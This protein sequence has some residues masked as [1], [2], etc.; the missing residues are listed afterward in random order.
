MDPNSLVLLAVVAGML[1]PMGFYLWKGW[2]LRSKSETIDGFFLNSGKL[3]DSEIEQTLV[4]TWM[5]VG[6]AIAGLIVMAYYY[7]VASF[8]AIITWVLGFLILRRHVPAIKKYCQR[9]ATLHGFL[10]TQYGSVIIKR[11]A[12]AV[13]VL[14]CLGVLS[15]E[16]IV[17]VALVHA[18][19]GIPSPVV[20]TVAFTFLFA[21]VAILYTA[22]GGFNAVIQTDRSQGLFIKIAIVSLLLIALFWTYGPIEAPGVPENFY[23]PAQ[24]QS[25]WE[26]LLNSADWRFFL[27][28][29]VF[30]LFLLPGDMGTWQRVNGAQS[31]TKARRGIVIA[32]FWTLALWLVLVFVGYLVK[33]APP[34]SLRFPTTASVESIVRTQ[35]EPLTSM[36]GVVRGATN[37]FEMIILTFATFAAVMGLIS[38]MLS[39]ADSYLIVIVQTLAMDFRFERQLAVKGALAD[40][41]L[42]R[43]IVN[44]AKRH[45]LTVGLL[46]LTAYWIIV[47]AK[48]PLLSIIF[49]VFSFQCTLTPIAVHALRRDVDPKR[50]SAIVLAAMCF[51]LLAIAFLAYKELTITDPALVYS[52][53]YLTPIAAIGIPVAFLVVGGLF[54]SGPAKALRLILVMFIGVRVEDEQ[55]ADEAEGAE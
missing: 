2:R 4:S 29:A 47:F 7:G 31:S 18:I 40:Q 51:S 3:T 10:G 43:T 37:P 38:A 24:G 5:S 42:N 25:V 48:Q 19:P 49:I 16:F 13:T 14:A 39:T 35:A 17:G 36:L 26:W 33:G 50:Y 41:R 30:Q 12:S 6:N 32:A 1:A 8:W 11:I 23:K 9:D 55:P 54:I 34:D 20:A 44:F 21:G 53:A 27:G 28:L 45:L 52:Y 22:L 15:L 46:G